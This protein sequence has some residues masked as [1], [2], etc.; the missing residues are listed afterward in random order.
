MTT[1][2]VAP[3]KPVMCMGYPDWFHPGGANIRVKDLRL[4]TRE[5][6]LTS[7]EA[8]WIRISPEPGTK[9]KGWRFAYMINSF[10]A[11]CS[12]SGNVIFSTEELLAAF[13]RPYDI[14]EESR[15][16]GRVLLSRYGGTGAI[17]GKYFFYVDDYYHY[18][19]IPGPGT[20]LD[21]DPNVSILN[22]DEIKKA[23]F[24]L[25]NY[26]QAE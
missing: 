24:Q 23:V 21:G 13:C 2:L 1:A 22:T 10:P 3:R 18:L 14:S 7:G 26:K 11:G 16:K 17:P 6:I 19:N 12:V 9:G 25:A 4:A 20:G 15:A 8:V 5:I